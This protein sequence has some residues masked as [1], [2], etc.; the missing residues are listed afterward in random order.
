MS[1]RLCVVLPGATRATAGGVALDEKTRSG[2][3]FYRDAW[4]GEVVAVATKGVPAAGAPAG[5]DHPGAPVPVE[6]ADPSGVAGLL[7]HLAPRVTLAPLDP[8]YA[9]LLDLSGDLVWVADLR[10]RVR[11]ENARLERPRVRDL[12]SP[13]LARSGL[14]LVRRGLRSRRLLERARG[15]QCNGPDAFD[16]YRR[17]S[18]A[19]LLYFDT[20]VRAAETAAA[21]GSERRRASTLRTAFS[22]RWIR[23]KGVLDAVSAV[24]AMPPGTDVR[25]AVIGSG[26]LAEEITSRAGPRVRALGHLDFHGEWVPAMTAE[27]D[28]MVLPHPQSDSAST[29]L[30]AMACGVPVLGYRNHYWEGLL[31]LSGGG[32]AT[33]TGDLPA[34]TR[35]LTEL[36]AAPGELAAARA[37]GL[38][39]AAAH[40]FEA[41]FGRRVDHLRKIADR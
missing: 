20:R 29:F 39:F 19:P 23:Q 6:I 12:L 35:R 25:L 10:E 17:H 15:V 37:R 31:D 40:T 3:A 21:A 9:A 5:E 36:A 13:S 16:A 7:R 38:R 8:T 26:P 27:T 4:P 32:W 28:L 2:L 30:E 11:W 14:G 1:D 33:S 41:E 34:L 18:P 24:Q 22:G